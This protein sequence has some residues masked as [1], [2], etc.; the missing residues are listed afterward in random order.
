MS[1][2]PKREALQRQGSL[3]PRPERVS[4]PLFTEDEFFDARDLIQVK[5]EMLRRVRREEKTVVKACS[6]FGFSR[7]SFYQAQAAFEQQGLGGLM[8]KKRGPR[9]G[10]KLTEEVMAFVQSEREQDRTLGWSGLAEKVKA[11]FG[12]EVHPRSIERVFKGMKKKPPS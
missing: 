9:S 1:D 10:H 7:P 8:P 11:R 6:S 2:N 4:D 3:N 12:I 5:Y